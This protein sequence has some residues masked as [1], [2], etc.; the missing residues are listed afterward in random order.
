MNPSDEQ[1]P[2]GTPAGSSDQ[3]EKPLREEILRDYQEGAAPGAVGR[4]TGSTKR[5]MRILRIVILLVIVGLAVPPCYRLLKQ[6]RAVHLID[7][8]GAAFAVGDA[9]EG[10][11]LMKQAL[12]LAPGAAAIQHAVEL[13][14][15]RVGDAPSMEKL[16]ARMRSGQ[17]GAEELLGIAELEAR[18]GQVEIAR[19][20]LG[21]LPHGI[22]SRQKLRR[23]L[24][25]AQLLAHSEG[26]GQASEF[27]LNQAA[28][29]ASGESA[30]LKIQGAVYLL[31]SRQPEQVRRAGDILAGIVRGRT[32]ASLPAWRILSKIAVMPLP[33]SKGIYSDAESDGLAGLLET[34]SGVTFADRLAAADMRIHADPTR[35]DAVV[36]GLSKISDQGN[37]RL[38]L[39]RWLNSRGQAKRV[40]ELGGED[41]PA[42]DTD[43]LLVVLDAHSALGQWK[44]IRAMMESPAAAGIPDAVRHLYL[45]RVASMTGDERGAEEEWRSVAGALHLEKPETLAYVAGY[46]EQIQAPEQ[47]RRAYREMADREETKVRGLVGLIRCQPVNAS[48]ATMIPL[49]EELLAASPSLP[50]ATCDLVYLRLLA[51]QDLPASASKAEELYE[52]QPNTLPRISTL[53]LARLR[54]GD[55]KGALTPYEGKAIDWASVPSPWKTVRVAV[56]KANHQARDAASLEGTLDSSQLRPEERALLQPGVAGEG[57]RSE[58]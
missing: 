14:N 16:L 48:A 29:L 47:A 3:S 8:S 56:L 31:S 49:Y 52:A 46:E 15:A 4:S 20:A 18:S 22:N 27:C 54:T 11:S 12:A 53:A 44:E 13:Y 10:I 2:A 57:R 30:R 55:P 58:R 6:W 21:K 5:V 23:L 25:E 32:D 50:D 28:S 51:G 26:A 7:R 42:K 37:H 43:W 41:L 9:E 33:E 17:S 36:K 35:L 19:E 24:V 39:A 34:L 45:A 40:I 38:D 1:Q